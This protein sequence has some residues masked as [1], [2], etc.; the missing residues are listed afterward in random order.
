MSTRVDMRHFKFLISG[1]LA[2][3]P[4]VILTNPSQVAEKTLLVGCTARSI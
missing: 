3:L 1:D 2:H 4:R